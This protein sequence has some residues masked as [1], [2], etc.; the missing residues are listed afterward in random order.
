[1]IG[2]SVKTGP[3]ADPCLIT[4]AV[5]QAL[6]RAH[7]RRQTDRV[8]SVIV[9]LTPHWINQAQL[10][11]NLALRESRTI[12]LWGGVFQAIVID[13]HMY[14]D[15]PSVGVAVIPERPERLH[16]A[17]LSLEI[18]Q[19]ISQTFSEKTTEFN[20][21][22][23][24]ANDSDSNHQLG[25]VNS[26]A[27]GIE[28][29]TQFS[30][31]RVQLATKNQLTIDAHRIQ[32]FDSLLCNDLYCNQDI[33][34]NDNQSN[35][36]LNAKQFHALEDIDRWSKDLTP[37]FKSSN[38]RLITIFG[39]AERQKTYRQTESEW[40]KIR[41]HWPNTPMIGALGKAAWIKSHDLAYNTITVQNHRLS[42][43]FIM[44]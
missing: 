7:A 4:Q 32:S 36:P 25:L 3:T 19:S 6:A 37:A 23:K 16:K 27:F 21:L 44:F 31:G 8:S 41:L 15:Q 14:A 2:T 1:M 34:Q 20:Q 30:Q 33:N 38:R 11:F 5:S 26:G 17:T 40:D 18:H 12:N 22:N 39:G 29:G 43:A 10:A 24:A 28:F 35:Q 13:G 9:F 42:A